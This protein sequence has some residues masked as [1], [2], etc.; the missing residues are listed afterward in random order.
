MG[1]VAA[2]V[3]A[4]PVMAWALGLA[5]EHEWSTHEQLLLQRYPYLEQVK[6]DY[7]RG[8]YSST[9]VVTYRLRGPSLQNFGGLTG[10]ADTTRF[11]LT[12]RNTIH[13]GPLPQMR[14]FAPATV[15]TEIVWPAPWR[16]KLSEL[17][18]KQPSL[19]IHSQLTWLGNRSIEVHSP[20][21]QHNAPDGTALTWRGVVGTAVVGPDFNSYSANGTA[22]GF[23]LKSAGVSLALENLT[24]QTDQR[25]VFDQV[26]TGPMKLR[27]DRL[28]IT[29]VAPAR[30]V[31]VQDF[32]LDGHSS[33]QGE[34]V[35][36]DAKLT[37]NTLQ[38]ADFAA[39]RLGYEIRLS[40]IHGP[41]LS[42]FT[43]AIQ[44]AQAQSSDAVAH[45]QKTQEAFKTEGVEILLR[46]PV[47][48]MP[49][50]EMAMPEGELLISLKLNLKGLS[51]AELDGPPALVGSA[52]AKHVQASAD[53]RIDTALLDKLLDSTGKGDRLA[54][55]LQGMQQQGYL[56][57]D[58]KALTTH[59]V[60]RNGQL[61]VNG[62]SFPAVGPMPPPRP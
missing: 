15:R 53:V 46:D 3:I 32:M 29:Q 55:P 12:L 18:G 27:L 13:H 58:G 25:S 19:I 36:M 31:S 4:Y 59:L 60:Y 44:A 10:G 34:Y 21:F 61:E 48:E 9:E 6:R 39:T 45:A 52:L 2:L 11:E 41:S 26:Y 40:H 62:R 57:L 14:A 22:A 30:R 51:R 54:A 16:A 5:T 43:K 38:M 42:A 47:F 24:F 33:A 1:V 50:I 7:R 49:R 23:S 20:P 17:F 37:A 8:V 35:D 28:D 56:K